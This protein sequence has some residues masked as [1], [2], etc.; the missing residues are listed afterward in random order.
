M[1]WEEP[2]GT[3]LGNRCKNTG[4]K[5]HILN[6]RQHRPIGEIAGLNLQLDRW[7]R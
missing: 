2:C 4:I 3:P 7:G 6:D 5:L 1:L